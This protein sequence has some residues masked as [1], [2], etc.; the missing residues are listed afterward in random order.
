[1]VAVLQNEIN[2]PLLRL[3]VLHC[4]NLKVIGFAKDG[5]KELNI[6]GGMHVLFS[7]RKYRCTA[8]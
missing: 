1:M 3:C 6:A 8:N 4:E 5:P 2:P 7:V